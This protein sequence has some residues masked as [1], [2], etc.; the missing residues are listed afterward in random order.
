[1]QLI[2][3][4]S[5][6]SQARVVEGMI[7]PEESKRAETVEALLRYD[8]IQKNHQA[9][10][11]TIQKIKNLINLKPINLTNDGL[12]ATEEDF[13]EL[14]DRL[15]MLEGTDI[16]ISLTDD[17]IDQLFD[18]MMDSSDDTINIKLTG[19]LGDVIKEHMGS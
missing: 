14:F 2:D 9:K 15:G 4:M 7:T 16:G 6:F 19:R 8:M 3:G 5:D 1:M 11:V 13:N 17:E 12:P 10:E 18:N